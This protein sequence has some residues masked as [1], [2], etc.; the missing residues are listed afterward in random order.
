REEGTALA[1]SEDLLREDGFPGEFLDHYMFEARFDLQGFAATYWSAD[2]GDLDPR[3]FARAIGDA[4]ANV[5][6]VQSGSPILELELSSR[7]VRAVTERGR[8][9]ATAAVLVLDSGALRL[10][11]GL[12]ERLRMVSARRLDSRLPDGPSLPAMARVLGRGCG[13]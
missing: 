11:P 4:V 2:E 8:V 12:A 3:A 7:G 5:A 10:V 13:W 1:D 9:N 6:R